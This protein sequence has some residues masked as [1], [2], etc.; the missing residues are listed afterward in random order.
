MCLL[1]IILIIDTLRK[2]SLRPLYSFIMM[3][4]RHF[5]HKPVTKNTKLYKQPNIVI[6]NRDLNID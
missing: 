6:D 5:H 4:P 2:R 1:K 3:Q